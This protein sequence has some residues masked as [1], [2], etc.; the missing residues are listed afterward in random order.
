MTKHVYR[1]ADDCVEIG[2]DACDEGHSRVIY[3]DRMELD[4]GT[5]IRGECPTCAATA[6]I[7]EYRESY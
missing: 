5:Q 6:F 7:N 4:D 3:I 1:F 2:Y